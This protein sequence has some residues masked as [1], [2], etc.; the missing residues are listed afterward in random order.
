MIC[1]IIE[2]KK[3]RNSFMYMSLSSTLSIAC[4]SLEGYVSGE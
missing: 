4:G 2:F 1:W 3:V